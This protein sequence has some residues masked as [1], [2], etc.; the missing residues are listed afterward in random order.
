MEYSITS[1]TAQDVVAT[2]T[3]ATEDIVV[4]NN[5]GNTTHTF[6][7]N[8]VF[9]FQFRDAVGNTGSVTATVTNINKSIPTVTLN[10]SGSMDIEQSGSYTEL[11][12]TWSDQ[13]DGTGAVSVISGSVDT[14]TLG[15]YPIE[16]QYTN[17]LG[18]VGST[19]RTVN[20]VDTIPPIAPT[21]TTPS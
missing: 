11:G 1:L 4:T 8:G 21:L 20:I 6:T 7:G 13:T 16:Y 10:G 3:G 12:A 2:L 5:A 19:T 18:V 9:I 15:V 17:S 14:H